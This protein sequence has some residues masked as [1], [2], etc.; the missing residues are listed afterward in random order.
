MRIPPLAAGIWSSRLAV[1]VMTASKILAAALFFGTTAASAADQAQ[2]Q[3]DLD[4]GGKHIHG[5]AR[6]LDWNMLSLADG[7]FAVDLLVPI[8]ALHSD[9]ATF[10]AAL[11]KAVEAQGK[12]FLEVQGTVRQNRFEG[13]IRI[14]ELEKQIE[15]PVKS[16]RTEG[17]LITTAAS[18]VDPAKCG[19]VL[20]GV[21]SATLSVTFRLPASG[22]AVYAGGSTHFVN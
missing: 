7:S 13:T 8:S 12:S 20:P 3:Y 10:D 9:D 17:M 21:T 6:E 22:N 5:V 11:L 14:A 16:S 19:I 18:Q 2:V 1:D 4:V 15:M